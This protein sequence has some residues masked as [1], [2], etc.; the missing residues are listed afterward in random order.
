V[1]EV[2][3]PYDSCSEPSNVAAGGDDCPVRFRCAGC[4]HFSTDISSL[5]DLETYLADLLRN[6]ERLLA[7]VEADDWTKADVDGLTDTE[8]SQ[9]DDAIT[10]VRRNHSTV[11][12]LG[13]PRARQPL[14]D[15]RPER[16]A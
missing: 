9:I 8:R 4:A 12:T 16:T 6:R 2:A 10:I 15:V 13:M 1:G 14:P 7:T 3:V 5:P 11:V